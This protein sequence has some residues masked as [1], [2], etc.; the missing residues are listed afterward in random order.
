[1]KARDYLVVV[2]DEQQVR[3]LSPDIQALAQ[4]EIGLGGVIVTAPGHDG[5]DYVVRFFA[6]SVGID[7]DPATGSITCTLAP[8]WST[9]LGKPILH[10]RQLSKRGGDIR[11]ETLP[12]RVNI[13]GRACL[14][15]QGA[16]EIGDPTLGMASDGLDTLVND[17]GEQTLTDVR[18]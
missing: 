3:S 4:I 15:L 10:A 9:R 2:D 7:E 18:P 1:M 8:Y 17:R 16:L 12:T 6:P 14:Y 13:T 11:A 5:V